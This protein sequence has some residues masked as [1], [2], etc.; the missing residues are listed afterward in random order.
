MVRKLLGA[1]YG[2]ICL[3]DLAKPSSSA[4]NGEIFIWDLAELSQFS[5]LKVCTFIVN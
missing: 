4:D 1:D 5:P 3:W 2:E